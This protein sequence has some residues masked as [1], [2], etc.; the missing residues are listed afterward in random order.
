M[1]RNYSLGFFFLYRLSILFFG[2]LVLTTGVFMCAHYIMTVRFLSG[3]VISS[4]FFVLLI[5]QLL[6]YTVPVSCF[7]ALGIQWSQL[8]IFREYIVLDMLRNAQRALQRAQALLVLV[9]WFFFISIIGWLGPHYYSQ[10][11]TSLVGTIEQLSKRVPARKVVPLWSAGKVW[12]HRKENDCWLQVR[13]ILSA[14]NDMPTLIMG[15]SAQVTE[16]SFLLRRGIILSFMQNHYT[17][18]RFDSL[19]IP[20]VQI[21]GEEAMFIQR[22]P[23]HYTLTELKNAPLSVPILEELVRRGVQAIFFLLFSWLLLILVRQLHIYRLVG[24]VGLAGAFLIALHA[25]SAI[26][27]PMILHAVKYCSVWL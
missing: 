18:S 10:A 17:S 7:L 21:M 5:P 26:C 12:Y 11:K 16:N 27:A 13:I 4:S 22:R 8:V 3:A 20:Y 23:K 6:S 9:A 1:R 15:H 25:I 19:T 14:K 24:V 2:I